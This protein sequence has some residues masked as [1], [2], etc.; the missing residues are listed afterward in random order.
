MFSC[1]PSRVR[2]DELRAE[3]A[4]RLLRFYARATFLGLF[5]EA[6]AFLHIARLG[7]CAA[8]LAALSILTVGIASAIIVWLRLEIIAISGRIRHLILLLLGRRGTGIGWCRKRGSGGQS[9]TADQ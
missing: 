8:T 9:Q 2:A 3:D 1:P 4:H 7:W 6:L 5:V